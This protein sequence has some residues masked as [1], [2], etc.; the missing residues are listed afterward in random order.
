ML[1]RFFDVKEI[2]KP[3]SKYNRSI[4]VSL[5]IASHY[6]VGPQVLECQVIDSAA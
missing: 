4:P 1:N 6:L 5:L 2:G 3:I